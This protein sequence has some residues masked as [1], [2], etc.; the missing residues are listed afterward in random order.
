MDLKGIQLLAT[1]LL[2]STKK[3]AI[4]PNTYKSLFA[5]VL[6]GTFRRNYLT[7]FTMLYLVTNG[8]P[9]EHTAFGSS[10]MDLARRVQEDLISLEYILHK[11]KEEYS[12]KFIE[13]EAVEAM[14]DIIYLEAAG[15]IVDVGLKKKTVKNY[16]KYKQ[17][18]FD[19]SG[20][21]KRKAWNELIE[22][23]K[24]KGKINDA[25]VHEIEVEFSKRYP[26]ND[27]QPRRSWAGVD[28]EGMIDVLVKD[29][30]INTDEERTLKQSYLKGNI[31]NHFSPTDINNFAYT[32]LYT[33]TNNDDLLLSIVTTT[34]GIARMA[35]MV[36]DEFEIPDDTRLKL[37]SMWQ[38]LLT[39][40]LPVK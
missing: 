32:D 26:N 1:E 22:Y 15:I 16:E 12:K 34:V 5:R 8:K 27:Q 33:I 3:F 20:K 31:K 11:G 10:C 14:R 18:F 19:K 30:V 21:A 13:Y 17:Q 7:L 35:N 28:V 36:A 40:H 29:G 38:T 4:G 6:E 39:A 2:N 23:L 24:K 9:D 37:K 25:D